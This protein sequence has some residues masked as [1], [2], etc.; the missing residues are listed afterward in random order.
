MSQRIKSNLVTQGIRNWNQIYN[1][2]FKLFYGLRTASK[3]NQLY[4]P[5]GIE[6]TNN[7]C[8]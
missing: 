3:H 8:T 6:Q 1:D 2:I 5:W 4:S 7:I